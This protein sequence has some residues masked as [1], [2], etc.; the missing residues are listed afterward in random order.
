MATWK[1][2]GIL[3]DL[4]DGVVTVEH[5]HAAGA[6]LLKQPDEECVVYVIED[7]IESYVVY[8]PVK[9]LPLP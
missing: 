6:P 4:T 2:R 5:S 7:L 3:L 9:E 1:E 8:E